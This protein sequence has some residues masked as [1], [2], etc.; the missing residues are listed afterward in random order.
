MNV[1]T[2]V[3]VKEGNFAG[4]DE[5]EGMIAVVWKKYTYS[6]EYRL[7]IDNGENIW[8]ES[9]LEEVGGDVILRGKYIVKRV[10]YDL[11][12]AGYK[13]VGW[14]DGILM[15][16]GEQKVY[17]DGKYACRVFVDKEDLCRLIERMMVY[18]VWVHENT[19]EIEGGI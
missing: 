11:I 9:T 17:R 12:E 18:R 8:D 1:G 14:K 13:V 3:R 4:A 10:I 5:Y 16:K 15:E 19:L 7:D 2:V 6:D